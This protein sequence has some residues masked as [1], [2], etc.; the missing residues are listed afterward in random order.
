MKKN[1]IMHIS[2]VGRL[3]TKNKIEVQNGNNKNVIEAENIVI[4]TGARPRS[5]PGM[6]FDG[7]RVISSK[8]AML[9]ESPPEKMIIIGITS[10]NQELE[11]IV[12]LKQ[13]HG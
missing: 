5:F 12:Q 1:K 7:S 11:E 8:E 2:G 13:I 10:K 3:I 4:A 9:I 6:E